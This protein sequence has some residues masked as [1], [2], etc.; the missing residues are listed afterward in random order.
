MRRARAVLERE[1]LE[2]AQEPL[3]ALADL[4]RRAPARPPAVEL[5][6]EPLRPRAVAQRGSS[7]ALS[8]ASLGDVAAGGLDRLVQRRGRLGAAVLAGEERDGRVRRRG[9]ASAGATRASTSASFQ[10]STPS[11]ITKRRPIANVIALSASAD[12]LGRRRVAL[13][14]LDARRRRSRPRPARAG[15]A[16][17][18][19]MRPWSSPWIR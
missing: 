6:A 7:A 4:R 2:L 14:D 5:E 15:C 13:E 9:R 12:G 17:R 3:L 19:A 8:V 11:T 18:S 10:R 16:R 1:L